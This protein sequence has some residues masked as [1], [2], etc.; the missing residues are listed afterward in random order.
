MDFLQSIRLF[1]SVAE[2][3]SFAKAAS[4]MR[5]ARPSVSNAIQALEAEVGARLLHRTTR[6]TTLTAEGENFYERTTQILSDIAEAKALYN[7]KGTPPRGRLRVDLPVALARPVIL[8]RLPEFAAQFPEIEIILGVSDAPADLVAEGIDCVVRLGSLQSSS[9]IARRIANAHMVNCAS[10]AYLERHGTPTSVH[11]LRSHQAVH[12]FSGRDRR[13]IDWHYLADGEERTIKMKPAL[14]VNDTEAFLHAGLA[15]FGLMQALGITVEG[16][17]GS[18][19]LIEILPDMRPS[20]RPI[21]ILY[22][23]K[24]HLAPQVRAFIEWVGEALARSPTT[25]IEPV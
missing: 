23:S 22:P 7:S 21:S 24:T 6:S 19:E 12:Y 15:G 10:P 9:M 3:G 4:A 25:W 14:S 16:H 2:H 11:D 1:V 20:P 8:P 5:M 18:G 17:L 13:V